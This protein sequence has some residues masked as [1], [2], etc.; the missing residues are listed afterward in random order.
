MQVVVS[1]YLR[2]RQT[3]EGL[4]RGWALPDGAVQPPRQ[5]PRLREQE[6]SGGLQLDDGAMQRVKED[7]KSEEWGSAKVRTRTRARART[8]MPGCIRSRQR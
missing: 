2:T 6:F 7:R 3:L 8:R 4:L 1:P 5:D